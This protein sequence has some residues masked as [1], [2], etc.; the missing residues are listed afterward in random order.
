MTVVTKATSGIPPTDTLHQKQYGALP[1]AVEPPQ[2]GDL[3]LYDRTVTLV[4]SSVTVHTEAGGWWCDYDALLLQHVNGRTVTCTR[5]VYKH[6]VLSGWV[7]IL[8]HP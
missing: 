4:L 5:R 8:R 1:A 2:V 6:R 7:T 3:V